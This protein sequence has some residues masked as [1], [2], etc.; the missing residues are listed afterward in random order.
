MSKKTTISLAILAAIALF[1]VIV[2]AEINEEGDLNIIS[3]AGNPSDGLGYLDLTYSFGRTQSEALA[4]ARANYP[5]ARMAKPSEFKDLFNASGLEYYTGSTGVTMDDLF[6]KDQGHV[7]H[8]C[9]NNSNVGPLFLNKLI[10]PSSIPGGHSNTVIYGLPD[11]DGYFNSLGIY[12]REINISWG[13]YDT[14]PK[15]WFIG[16]LIVVDSDPDTDGDGVPDSED[17]F[18][19]DPNEWADADKDGVGDNADQNDDSDLRENVAVGGLDTGISNDVDDSGLSLQDRIN[20]LETDVF[21]HHGHYVRTMVYGID[22][23]VD[24]EL[25]TEDEADIMVSCAAQSNIGK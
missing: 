11:D 12:P 5:S 8:V 15:H 22:E 17:V 23:L 18:P 7:T 4:A 19:E 21:F 1:P 16:W 10:D 14:D 2:H 13:G 20:T 6:E 24:A 25:I 9:R 3:Q